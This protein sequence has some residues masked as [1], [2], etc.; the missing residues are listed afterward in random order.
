[1]GVREREVRREGGKEEGGGKE[2]GG[3]RE[4][5]TTICLGCLWTSMMLGMRLG[6]HLWYHMIVTIR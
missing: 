1:M 2:G 5:G 3:G 4:G 6:M